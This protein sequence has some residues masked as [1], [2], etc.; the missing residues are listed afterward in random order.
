MVFSPRCL[1]RTKPRRKE[2]RCASETQTDIDTHRHRE[3]ERDDGSFKQRISS[4]S[5]EYTSNSDS[6]RHTEVTFLNVGSAG[7]FN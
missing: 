7:A 6:Q 3:T 1:D 2:L 5:A 4:S